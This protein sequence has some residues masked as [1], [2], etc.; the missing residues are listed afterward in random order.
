M[1]C[2]REA[3]ESGGE[4]QEGG[5]GLDEVVEPN[6][7]GLPLRCGGTLDLLLGIVPLGADHVQVP[8]EGLQVPLC[9]GQLLLLGLVLVTHLSV[10]GGVSRYVLVRDKG[11]SHLGGAGGG[12]IRRPGLATP[13]GWGLRQPVGLG[14]RAR[15]G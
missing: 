11:L 2:G 15:G 12:A 1:R 7:F 10:I 14:R 8:F 4:G 13:E 5:Q 9:H 3:A 6:G